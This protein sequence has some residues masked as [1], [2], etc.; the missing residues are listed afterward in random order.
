MRKIH[1]FDTSTLIHDPCSYKYFAHSDVVIP[2]AVLNELDDLKKHDGEVGKQ[3]RVAI[4]FI[5]EISNKGDI[6]TGILIDDDIMV[7]VD[8]S[9]YDP[10]NSKYYGFGNPSYGD[11]QILICTYANWLEHPERDVSLVSRDINLRIKAKSRGIDAFEHEGDKLALNELYE[12]FR[13]IV[14]ESAG[15]DLQKSGSIDPTAYGITLFPNECVL[16]ENQNG[17]GIAMGR[18]VAPDRLRLIKKYH[19]WGI[20]G[21]NKEQNF[22][23]DLLMDKNIDLVTFIGKAGT[24]KSLITLAAAMELVCGRKE[25]D[26]FIIYRPIQSVGNDIGY[27]PGPQPL[28]AKIATPKGWVTMGDIQPEDFII[29]SDGKH[30]KVLNI[31]PKG[32]KEVFKVLFSDGSSTECCDDHLWYTTT[33]QESQRK[34]GLGSIKSLKEIRDTLKVYKTQVNNHKIPLIKPVEFNSEENIINPYIMGVLLGDGTLSENYS[35]YFTSSDEQIANNCSALLPENML[36][37]V[38]SAVK[39]SYN[40][41]FIMKN[42][43]N[44][45]KRENNIFSEEIKRLNL[46]GKKSS[47]KF[48]PNEYKINSTENRLSILQGLMDTDGFVSQDGSDVSYSTTSEQLAL[49]IQFLVQSLGGI[50]KITNKHSTYSYGD[51]TRILN[52]KVVSVSLPKDMCP[53]RLDRKIK[54]F[55]SRKHDLNRMIVDIVS[56]GV[57]ETK[58]IL[59][60]SEDHLYATDNFILTHNT[61]EEKLAPWFQAIMDNMEAL[62]TVK[63]GDNWRRELE[64]FQRKG[65]IE[66]EAITYIR[67]RSI[68]NSIIMI[69]ECQ[70]LSK[71]EVKTILTRAG[72]GTKIVLTGDIEQIDN[73][74]LDATSNGLAYVIEKFKTSNLAGHVTFI[75][76]ERS[77]LATLASEIL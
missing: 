61:M 67:G 35:V 70:N 48:I 25:Y 31:F 28:D 13:V 34:E 51:E 36:C 7:K 20:S 29:G 33:L 44:N 64:V 8:A 45:L 59:V 32:E 66:M 22:A 40:Y 73:S 56:V 26:K 75:Q 55:K 68:P 27:L 65:L 23:F 46:L 6:S 24:G 63:N 37:K 71:E 50:S 47:N 42:N 77:K 38:K 5:D 74:S 62:L 41:S 16:F 15:L 18:K 19:P 17:D 21:R 57:K 52:S 1:I 14:N 72:E 3:A 54:R 12:G 53:F 58:C 60:E 2:I 43:L 69:D 49:D 11:T 10:S 4:K 30:K 39:N 76:G 9:Y